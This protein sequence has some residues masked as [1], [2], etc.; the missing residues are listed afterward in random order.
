M[1]FCSTCGAELHD[2]AIIC[3]KCGCPQ[4]EG[5]KEKMRKTY[6]KS[7]KLFDKKFGFDD[8]GNRYRKRAC[9]FMKFYKIFILICWGICAIISCISAIFT[10]GLGLAIIIPISLFFFW[11]LWLVHFWCMNLYARGDIYDALCK[12]KNDNDN[13]DDSK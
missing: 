1:K 4:N 13:C 5:T 11:I 6:K 9:F 10:F 2:E 7:N 8:I 3:P 12:A